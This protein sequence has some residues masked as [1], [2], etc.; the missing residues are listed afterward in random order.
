MCYKSKIGSFMRAQNFQLF[1]R[2]VCGFQSKEYNWYTS[3]ILG[4]T[5]YL[6]KRHMACKNVI[7]VISSNARKVGLNWSLEATF[8]NYTSF[9]QLQL[10]QSS[11]AFHKT[12]HRVDLEFKNSQAYVMF[13]QI[14]YCRF[15]VD[16]FI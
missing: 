6:W 2:C 10:F 8:V 1:L 4:G 5:W 9:C 12:R 14:L 11:S 7:Y 15:I 3:Y 16:I 13:S